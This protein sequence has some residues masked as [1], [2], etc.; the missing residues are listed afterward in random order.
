MPESASSAITT[1]RRARYDYEILETFEAGIVLTGSEIKSIRQGRVN[2]REAYAQVKNGEMWL[3]NAHISPYNAAGPFGQHDPVRPRKLLLHRSQIARIG[4]EVD[5]QRITL[6]PLRLYIS[7]RRAKVEL[8]LAKG[9]RQYDRRETIKQ[10][11][12]KREMDRAL[13]SR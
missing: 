8:A 6:V 3:Y 10:R 1:N 2:I 4:F 11:D 7:R 9:K 12:A 13:K 5:R